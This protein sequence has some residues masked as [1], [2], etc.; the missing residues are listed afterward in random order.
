MKVIYYLCCNLILAVAFIIGVFSSV[1]AVF[2]STTIY[3]DSFDQ[4][5][6]G[7]DLTTATYT[8]DTGS[9]NSANF[10]VFGAGT[11][12]SKQAIDFG[13]STAVFIDQPVTTGSE[14]SG[15]FSTSYSTVSSFSW[16]LTVLGSNPGLGGFFIR[17][18]SPTFGMQILLGYLD[19]GQIGVFTDVPSTSTLMTIGTYTP[20]QTYSTRLDY[21][22]LLDHYS[23]YVDGSLLLGNQPIPDYLDK[24]SIDRFGFDIAET[25]PGSMGNQ[26]V[27]DNVKVTVVPE[28]ISCILFTVGGA[29]LGLK[30]FMRRKLA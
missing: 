23:V 15:G 1:N 9:T 24:T 7:T 29:T 6:E 16:D 25:L 19:D 20:N 11:G 28:P 10:S 17:F 4:F 30:R 27:L 21:N 26:F 13:G 22:L 14:Y 3:A 8:P 2:A 12:S 5:A 18:P